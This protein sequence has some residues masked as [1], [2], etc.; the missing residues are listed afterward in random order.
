MDNQPQPL[1]APLP[2]PEIALNSQAE[3]LAQQFT[4]DYFSSL[5]TLSKIFALRGKADQVQRFHVEMARYSLT[6]ADPKSWTKEFLLVLGGALL[7]AFI[8][9]FIEALADDKKPLIV[10]YV[11]AGFIGVV[12][13]FWALRRR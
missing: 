12:M 11:I 10:T 5:V 1:P 13:V 3:E 4:A 7:G 6:Q 9:G 8:Q 2:N